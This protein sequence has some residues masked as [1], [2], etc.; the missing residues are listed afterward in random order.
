MFTGLNLQAMIISNVFGK[1]MSV[2][3]N[4]AVK[5]F[6]L[7]IITWLEEKAQSTDNK[8][9]DA[10]LIPAMVAFRSALEVPDSD[11][12]ATLISEFMKMV[13]S[14]VFKEM[15]DAMLDWLED[16]ALS[17]DTKYDDMIVIPLCNTVRAAFD[18][19]DND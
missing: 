8:Y 15:A 1:I 2:F 7:Y 5:E 6:A 19:P 13:D 4:D 14:G 12:V 17:T 18:I 11:V 9:D 16:K 10:F 3:N